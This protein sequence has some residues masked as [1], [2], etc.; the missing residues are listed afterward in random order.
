[1]KRKKLT[2]IRIPLAELNDEDKKLL[3]RINGR[4]LVIM[5]E[6]PCLTCGKRKR[7]VHVEKTNGKRELIKDCL[8]CLCSKTD[9]F[10]ITRNYH[11]YAN[12]KGR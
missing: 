5:A 3:N 1:M 10:G 2:R 6:E 11:T 7:V 9:Q 4:Y 12:R 8:F